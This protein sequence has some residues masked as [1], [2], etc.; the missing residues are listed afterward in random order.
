MSN[1][2][3]NLDFFKKASFFYNS[4]TIKLPI[5]LLIFLLHCNREKAI[6][7]LAF[8]KEVQG[9]YTEA[10]YHYNQA[11]KIN[12]NYS[13]ANARLGFLL[14]ESQLS[15]IPAIHHLEKAR[16]DSQDDTKISLKLIDLTL[17]I[18]DFENGRRLQKEIANKISPETSELIT[19]IAECLEA[20]TPKDK[21]KLM[22]EI[23]SMEFPP[24]TNMIYRSLAL[25]YENGGESVKAEEIVT[26]YRRTASLVH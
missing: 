14:S 20:S 10:I 21:H 24:D 13:F 17:F 3:I 25:C 15:I 6:A 26:N 19:K 23:D 9:Y 4:F 2:L 5:L 16:S 18:L 1:H 7:Q 12:P 11:L 8:E 22:D